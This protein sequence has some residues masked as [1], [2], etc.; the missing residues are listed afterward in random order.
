MNAAN[1]AAADNNYSVAKS[2]SACA[3]NRSDCRLMADS[4][5]LAAL[6]CDCMDG[7]YNVNYTSAGAAGAVVAVADSDGAMMK[8][9]AKAVQV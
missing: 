4:M 2:Y 5:N 1:C 9:V 6:D 7:C 3:E 8:L